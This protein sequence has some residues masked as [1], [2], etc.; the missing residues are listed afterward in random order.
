MGK[1][2]LVTGG[3]RSGK[4]TFAEE[5]TASLG[6]K[7]SYIATAA[8]FDDAMKDR[9]KKHRQQRPSVWKTF[10]IYDDSLPLRLGDVKAHGDT[11]LLDCLTVMTTNLM[12]V[13]FSVD[14][15]R[16]PMDEVNKLELKIREN[17]VHV[18][19]GIRSWDLDAVIVTN[20]LGMGI[21]PE[22]RLAR[23]Y[24]DIAGRINQMV[25]SEADEVYLV[26]SGIPM[27]IK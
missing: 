19:E 9:I 7:I 20:E 25:A 22:N 10:E 16:I 18:I 15:D 14:W 5:K 24:R 12:L 1:I 8:P 4:S 2:V 6:E 11:M 21:V 27:Q 23:L 3:A 17:I 13:D 26:V